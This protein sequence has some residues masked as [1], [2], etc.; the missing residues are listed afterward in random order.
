MSGELEHARAF[1]LCATPAATLSERNHISPCLRDAL[2]VHCHCLCRVLIARLQ[3]AQ[4]AEVF[5]QQVFVQLL[6]RM[7]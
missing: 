5:E 7:G 3:M 4:R 1:E 6:I 2:A